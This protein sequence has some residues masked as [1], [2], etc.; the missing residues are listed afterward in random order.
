MKKV[1][2]K[3]ITLFFLLVL[4]SLVYLSNIGIKTD[5]FNNRIINKVK[6]IDKNLDI[7]LQ[8]VNIL[9]DLFKLNIKIKTIGANLI[10]GTKSL[11][12]ENLKS[13]ISIKSLI[14]KNFSIRNLKISTKT[15]KIEDLIS[16]TRL[17]KNDAK[18]YIAEKLI[19]KGFLVADLNIEFD[20]EGKIK[21]NYSIKGFVKDGKINF[22][23]NY[24][25]SKIFFT[26]N[27]KKEYFDFQDIKISINDN[28][29]LIPQLITK[30]KK[31][32]YLINGT[33]D[34]KKIDLSQK[35]INLINKENSDLNIQKLEFASKNSFFF[36]LDKKF[37]IKNLKIDSNID[38]KN[39]F[40]FN[41]ND[42]LQKILPK[43]EKKIK[44]QNHKLKLR[45]DK[46]NLN[47]DGLGEFLI[48]NIEDKIRYK[49]NKSKKKITFDLGFEIIKNQI[50][51]DFINYQKKENSNLEILVSGNKISDNSY[52]LKKISFKENDN[53]IEIF[54]LVLIN[55]KIDK[56]KI[57]DFNYFDK[58]NL[59]NKFRISKNN[60]IYILKGDYLNL[61]QII[62][63]VLISNN[64]KKINLFKNNFK[65][66]INVKE[67]Y[68]DKKSITKNL[69]GFLLFKKNKIINANL[70]SS[71][72]DQK[73][74]KLTIIKKDNQTVTTLYSDN[75]KP[76]V[77]RYKFIKGFEEGSLD[78]YSIEKNNTTN[79]KLKIYDFKLKELPVLT[80][81]LTLASLQ[82][83]ADL[84]S[85]EGIR[86]NEFEMNF[87]NNK[88]LMTINEIYSIGPAISILMDGYVEKN[89]LLSLRG[90]LV[91]A[92]TLNKI[93]GSIPFLGDILV[94]NNVGEG[95]FGVSFKIKGP[96]KKL[97]T[98][99]NPIKTL[100]PRFITRTLEKIKKN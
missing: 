63:E 16:F 20:K 100:T 70:I 62:E 84:L 22:P 65:L 97:E 68:L 60:K 37:N 27:I 34:H 90:T 75:A 35:N 42:V 49:I 89:K 52:L 39:L 61:N 66:K 41:D 71:F 87:S 33:V 4:S 86:F 8:K 9:L 36:N 78:F 50:N 13:T 45:Y 46:D 25:L 48:Q 26:F 11:Q 91:P 5:K 30:K 93:I 12:L 29:L 57:I 83:V 74:I 56:F 19:K 21:D 31:D 80:K 51:L 77:K 99:V 94:G 1:I 95:V 82:G 92:T 7:E 64:K 54:D 73:K 69:N 15:L 2:Y 96:P 81:I 53:K 67:A 98:T 17:F 43:F 18:L 55:N 38:L 24:D 6:N 79:S 10:Y 59:Q 3:I 40:F 47:I 85:G 76:F 72:S 58:E 44:L 14:N 28:N 23:K 32:N 88:D